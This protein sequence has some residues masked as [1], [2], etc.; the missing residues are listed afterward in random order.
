MKIFIK[1]MVCGRCI[2]AVS[3]IFNDF[4]IGIQS[5]QLGEVETESDISDHDMRSIETELEKT[6]FER[7]KDSSINLLRKSK[8]SLLPKSA[9]SILMKTFYYQNFWLQKYIR[10]TVPFQKPF[11]KMRIL[12]WSSF[13]SFK[14]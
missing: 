1:N 2:S 4:G 5:I 6:G 12:L 14:K 9:N 13:L 8:I 3:S 7:I 10:I 11:P